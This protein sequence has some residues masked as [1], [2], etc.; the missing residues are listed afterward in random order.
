MKNVKFILIPVVSV[1]FLFS[2]YGCGGSDLQRQTKPADTPSA[3]WRVVGPGG[4]GG[5][6]RPTIS[7]H[8]GNLAMI[9][10]DMTAAY[11]TADG[12]A[13]WRS[14]NLWTTPEDFEFDPVDPEVGVFLVMSSWR[15]GRLPQ[16]NSRRMRWPFLRTLPRTNVSATSP[17]MTAGCCGSWHTRSARNMLLNWVPRPA[18]REFGWD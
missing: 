2:S 8:D 16:T 3:G 7:P 12:G 1:L 17:S 6:F 18:Y 13:S 4:G 10:C 11:I 9:H 5:M 14:V 15:K